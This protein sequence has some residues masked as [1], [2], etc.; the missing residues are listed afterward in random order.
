MSE[1]TQHLEVVEAS[2]RAQEQA[3]GEVKGELA[4]AEVREQ[5]L[6]QQLQVS[7]YSHLN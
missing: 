6:Q 4:A 7:T 5:G 3:H 2:L 1:L